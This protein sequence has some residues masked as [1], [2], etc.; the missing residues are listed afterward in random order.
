MSLVYKNAV[1]SAP[2]RG[3]TIRQGSGAV[4]V[5]TSR[6]ATRRR[7]DRPGRGPSAVAAAILLG[8]G[9]AAGSGAGAAEAGIESLEAA[10]EMIAAGTRE[11]IETEL[12]LEPA[13]AEAFWPV[14]ERFDERMNLLR[15][16][17]VRLI[18]TYMDRYLRGELDEAEANRMTDEYFAL[19]LGMLRLRQRFLDDFREAIG[20]LKTARLYQLQ[21]K[22][23]AELDYALAE[24][25]PLTET[26]P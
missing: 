8:A 26:V 4:S 25:V 18:E 6:R 14:Y 3:R 10:R 15:G 11:L 5:P 23:K 22:V 12:D 9:L 21:N 19:Q 13:E 20:G 1:V 24:A 16:Q 7:K 17:Y 2:A